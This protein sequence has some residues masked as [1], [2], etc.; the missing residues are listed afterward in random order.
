MP[1]NP[2]W[3][4]QPL[5][6]HG[7]PTGVSTPGV[8]LSIGQ[9]YY[10]IDTTPYASYVWRAGAWHQTGAGVA[11]PTGPTGPT[12]ATGATGATGPTGP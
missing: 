8:A 1:Q 11:G 2:I 4:P 12:G 5:F 3:T 6:G 7:A 9:I 10:N